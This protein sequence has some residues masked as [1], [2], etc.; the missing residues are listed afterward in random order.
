MRWKLNA[1]ERLLRIFVIL[2]QLS[3]LR[4]FYAILCY[5]LTST[6]LFASNRTNS[7]RVKQSC[8][9]TKSIPCPPASFCLNVRFALTTFKLHDTLIVLKS[10][11][12][13]TKTNP[14]P[15]ITCTISSRYCSLEY[16]FELDVYRFLVN[17]SCSVNYACSV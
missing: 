11:L 16:S 8:L 17:S 12:H 13:D 6:A 5:S 10:S 2:K 1:F 9:K 4:S 7:R 15:S 3:I 14:I